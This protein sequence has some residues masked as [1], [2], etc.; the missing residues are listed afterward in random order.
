MQGLHPVLQQ[1]VNAALLGQAFRLEV[2]LLRTQSLHFLLLA[3]DVRV[4]A[5]QESQPLR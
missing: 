3:I 2:G 5:G 1:A 4:Q